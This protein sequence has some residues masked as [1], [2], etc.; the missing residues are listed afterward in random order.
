MSKHKPKSLLSAL[1]N[2]MVAPAYRL[3]YHLN[4]DATVERF[5]LKPLRP[6]LLEM[7][8]GMF[9]LRDNSTDVRANTPR[10]GKGTKHQEGKT[11]VELAT[12]GLFSAL[13]TELTDEIVNG[14]ANLSLRHEL[15][16]LAP[17]SGP[18]KGFGP[19]A[20][21]KNGAVT[22]QSGGLLLEY[23][24]YFVYFADARAEIVRTPAVTDAA[25]NAIVSPP[26]RPV[27]AAAVRQALQNLNAQLELPVENRDRAVV[28]PAVQVLVDATHNEYEDRGKT[29]MW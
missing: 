7:D 26:Q 12:N 2:T 21:D 28:R 11:A 19:I 6:T 10:S 23:L 29:C 20:L 4:L 3:E 9:L 27:T 8:R 24:Y 25:T 15:D 1:F 14:T 18:A 13:V 22:V 17:T 16:P 5:G